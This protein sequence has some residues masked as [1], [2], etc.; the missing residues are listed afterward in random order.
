MLFYIVASLVAGIASYCFYRKCMQKRRK[1]DMMFDLYFPTR[2]LKSS[3]L[4]RQHLLDKS[5]TFLECNKIN[6][7]HH[8]FKTLEFYVAEKIIIYSMDAMNK[9]DSYHQIKNIVKIDK[10]VDEYKNI[11]YENNEL[12][13]SL[14]HKVYKNM[15][16]VKCDI[17][18]LYLTIN[19]ILKITIKRELNTEIMTLRKNFYWHQGMKYKAK[20]LITFIRNN[21]N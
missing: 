6:M 3:R 4:L 1:I 5:L 14:A 17:Y 15:L 18:G 12:I 20:G 21:F 13:T 16:S 7:S 8:M 11:F 19:G 9:G 2:E 10:L